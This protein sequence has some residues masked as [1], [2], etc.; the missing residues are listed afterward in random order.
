M[1]AQKLKEA[2]TVLC[3]YVTV[4]QLSE[5]FKNFGGVPRVCFLDPQSAACK[6]HESKLQLGIQKI[7]SFNHFVQM[8]GNKDDPALSLSVHSCC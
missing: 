7:K 6:R 8:L 4:D 5:S 3:L 1:D 2:R